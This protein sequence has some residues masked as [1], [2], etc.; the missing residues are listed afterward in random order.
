MKLIINIEE[1]VIN[2]VKDY[3]RNPQNSKEQRT[4][5]TNPRKQGGNGKNHKKNGG[6]SS[7]LKGQELPS[8]GFCGRKG[9]TEPAC[10]IKQKSMASAKK[11]T[12]DRCT[13]LCTLLQLSKS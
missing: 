5:T 12:K 1:A 7:I 2:P 10:R 8:C 6:E 13:A 4:K 11:D 3:E 9:H